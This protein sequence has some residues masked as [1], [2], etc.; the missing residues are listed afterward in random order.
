MPGEIAVEDLLPIAF[1]LL[2]KLIKLK[3]TE[4]FEKMLF[5][6][7]GISFEHTLL[8]L[9]KLYYKY[10]YKN[11]ARDAIFNSIKTNNKI[12]AETAFILSRMV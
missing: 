5:L 4:L 2:E 9:A 6:L 11:S 7:D 3:E 10:D 1:D 8:P 12:D